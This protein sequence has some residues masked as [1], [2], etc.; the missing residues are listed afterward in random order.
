MPSRLKVSVVIPAYNA[1]AYLPATIDS[2]LGQNYENLELIVIDDGSTDDTEERLRPYRERIRIVSQSN[3]GCSA[4][5]NAG[6]KA[7]TGELVAFLDSDDLWF[8]DK[9]AMQVRT[10]EQVPELGLCFTNYEEF[11]DAEEHDGF[12]EGGGRIYTLKREPLFD[13]AFLITTDDLLEHFIRFGTSPCWTSTV[14]VRRSCFDKVGLF[15]E[16]YTRPSVEDMHMWMRLAKYFRFA[17]LDHKLVR[18]RVRRAR[19]YV[20]PHQHYTNIFRHTSGMY[21]T[22]DQWIPLTPNQQLLQAKRVADYEFAWGYYE[23][24]RNELIEARKHLKASLMRSFSL[25][26]ARCL[27]LSYLPPPLL[28]LLRSLRQ[29]MAAI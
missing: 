10:F 20:N 12:L 23:F 29:R 25:K 6:I 13:G 7:A 1:A 26:V 21:E 2:V 14:L 9:L 22:L 27:L 5:R 28:T 8:P 3:R 17:Y 4:A 19:Y 11:E 16:V 18:R 24:S 15:D